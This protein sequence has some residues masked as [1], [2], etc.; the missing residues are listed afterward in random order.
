MLD[1]RK[2]LGEDA[3]APC[4]YQE[5]RE[6]GRNVGKMISWAVM[7]R[8]MS[9]KAAMVRITLMLERKPWYER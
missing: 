4:W 2:S 6:P 9:L 5:R 8:T 1:N 3:T 7:A